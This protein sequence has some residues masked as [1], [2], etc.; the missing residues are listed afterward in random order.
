MPELP[1]PKVVRYNDGKQRTYYYHLDGKRI[2]KANYEELQRQLEKAAPAWPPTRSAQK[3][4]RTVRRYLE[5]KI[6]F[7]SERVRPIRR[8]LGEINESAKSLK[9]IA[10]H[11][12]SAIDDILKELK[13]YSSQQAVLHKRSGD[14]DFNGPADIGRDVAGRDK[15]EKTVV[16]QFLS[17]PGDDELTRYLLLMINNSING[18][19]ETLA[20]AISDL[21]S[22]LREQPVNDLAKHLIEH[23]L[24]SID[25]LLAKDWAS[26]I[27]EQPANELAKHLIEHDLK[28]VDD[29]LAKDWASLIKEQPVN[30]L[31]NHIAEHDLKL[32]DDL[33]R[34]GPLPD[35]KSQMNDAHLR[36]AQLAGQD[37]TH[38]SFVGADLAQV[39]LRGANLQGVSLEEANLDG[40]ILR[41]AKL[42]K[43]NL[44]SA[45]LGEADLR[46]ANLQDADLTN[47][48]LTNVDLRETDLTNA[49][50]SRA[51]LRGAKITE[52]QLKTVKS[53][54]G[55]IMPDGTIRK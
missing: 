39:D 47:V 48:Y 55:A 52:D 46:R 32:I 33:L 1:P 18:S 45:Y 6:P 53:L 41:G 17:H 22:S 4:K 36:D 40:A 43:A 34:K 2:S 27:K 50:L 25:D 31:A 9:N 20:S 16:N 14:A 35:P 3:K 13:G 28:S 54:S 49:D 30:D 5:S 37:L 7:R 10:E 23:D 42:Q 24:K 11:D 38:S 15:V 8:F 29:L 19:T 26:L 12:R 51:N 21:K 44:A